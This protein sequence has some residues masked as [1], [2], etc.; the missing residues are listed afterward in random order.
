MSL[1]TPHPVYLNIPPE[2]ILCVGQPLMAPYLGVTDPLTHKLEM[3]FHSWEASNPQNPELILTLKIPN[4][5]NLA[6]R[7]LNDAF[8]N[9]YPSSS[10]IMNNTTVF[11]KNSLAITCMVWNVQGA[12][13]REF[14]AVLREILRIHKPMVFALVETHMGG[15]H[16]LRI[17]NLVHYEGHVRVDAQGFSGG[18]WVYWKE[19]GHGHGFVHCSKPS[20]LNDGNHEGGGDTVVF[21][22]NLCKSGPIEKARSLGGAC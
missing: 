10:G 3:E 9:Q 19:A 22:C 8:K 17:A 7:Q 4:R 18:I 12:G 20:I 21:N 6:L 15:D 11:S 2:K 16:A 1:H 13:S 14:L 5:I